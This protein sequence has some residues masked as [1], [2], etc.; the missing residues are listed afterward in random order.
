M[1]KPKYLPK[2]KVVSKDRAPMPEE[3]QR[4]EDAGDPREKVIVTTIAL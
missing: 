1:L 2:P 3:L 4:L